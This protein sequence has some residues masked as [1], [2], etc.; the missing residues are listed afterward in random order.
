MRVS[1][2]GLGAARVG[3]DRSDGV[4]TAGRAGRGGLEVQG[5]TDD[6]GK[7]NG[8]T[9]VLL[10]VHGK[11]FLSGVD[12]LQVRGAGLGAGLFTSAD[13][14]GNRDGEQDADDQDNDHDFDK[15]KASFTRDKNVLLVGAFHEK[16]RFL[17]RR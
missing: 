3:A 15:G 8:V 5:G 1:G 11:L 16:D 7:R 2:A 13:E 17:R 10:L 9:R 14:V 12:L 6:I 4:G